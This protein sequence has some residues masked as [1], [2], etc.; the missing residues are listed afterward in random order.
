[1]SDMYRPPQEEEEVLP[2][3]E[4]GLGGPGHSGDLF[5]RRQPSDAYPA[6]VS[7]A[8][9]PSGFYTF[10][11]PSSGVSAPLSPI[12]GAGGNTAFQQAARANTYYPNAPA[13]AI[14]PIPPGGRKRG[15]RRP[16][17]I[18]ALVVVLLLLVPMAA[19]AMFFSGAS[20]MAT[21]H[22][23]GPVQTATARV[24]PT[25]TAAHRPTPTV[26]RATPS[27][28][29]A[30][31]ATTAT[32]T[33]MLQVQ[34]PAGWG[35]RS[36]LDAENAL[37]VAWTFTQREMR[38]DFRNAGTPG[39]PAG[40]LTGAVFLLTP[41]AQQRFRANDK[42]SSAAFFAQVQNSQLIQVP[43]FDN[44]PF[45]SHM[46]ILQAEPGQ[47]GAFF[48]WVNVPFELAIQHGAG[49]HPTIELNQQT[50]QPQMHI[51]QVLLLSVPVGSGPMGGIDY[52]VSNYALDLQQGTTLPIPAQP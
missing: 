8:D 3:G 42:R 40:S 28:T 23:A 37:L 25:T 7:A 21:R 24:Q 9:Q 22:P 2:L 29:P 38:I 44:P 41:A 48:A 36:P 19:Y 6:V 49:G 15:I 17:K 43:V 11:Q 14:A 32:G 34:L 45:V 5:T 52:E 1:M 12:A 31:T 26:G 46:Q 51:M 33:P 13:P 20:P 35:N 4:T 10:D 18:A 27:P 47:G 16:L 39:H 50:Q 30:V